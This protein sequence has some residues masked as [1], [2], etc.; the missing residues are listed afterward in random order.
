M[1]RPESMRM[2][3]DLLNFGQRVSILGRATQ[4]KQAQGSAAVQ[5]GFALV[6]APRA[7][8]K[9]TQRLS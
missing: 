3:L 7:G 8:A 6:P 4:M 5:D 9:S 1:E 2:S